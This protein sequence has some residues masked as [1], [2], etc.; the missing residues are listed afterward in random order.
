MKPYKEKITDNEWILGFDEN[1][2]NFRWKIT[3]DTEITEE[4]ANRIIEMKY[5]ALQRTRN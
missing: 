5:E 4:N 3:S 2:I 1:D